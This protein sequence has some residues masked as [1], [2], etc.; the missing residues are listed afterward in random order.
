VPLLIRHPNGDCA[1]QRVGDFVQHQDIMPTVL[2]LAGQEIPD[3]VLGRDIWPTTAGKA[4]DYVVQA[5][6]VYACIR[7]K[8]WNYI[9]PWTQP[10]KETPR[11]ELY[12]L[13]ADPQELT[14]VL[15]QHPDV[16]KDLSAK[17]DAHMAKLGPMTL[18][19]AGDQPAADDGEMSAD[20][21]M[22]VSMPD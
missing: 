5:F 9:R 14:S 1:G 6:G 17:L 4:P 18:S 19:S 15:D 22:P 3:R 11:E 20:C 10:G 8:Q 12:D 21:V 16:A 13:T 7:T 2:K